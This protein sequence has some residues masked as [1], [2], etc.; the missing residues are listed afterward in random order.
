MVRPVGALMGA[1]IAWL[2]A[3]VQVE[4][5]VDEARNPESGDGQRRQ[6]AIEE[7]ITVRR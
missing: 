3:D 5:G 1:E 6:D 7:R 2:W 4:G